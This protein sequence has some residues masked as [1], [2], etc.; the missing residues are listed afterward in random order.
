M[1][2][3]GHGSKGENKQKWKLNSSA[4]KVDRKL[5]ERKA[6]KR[7]EMAAEQEKGSGNLE[8]NWSAERNYKWQGDQK[9]SKTRDI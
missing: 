8:G 2:I 9:T 5:R 6:E 3:L 4:Y 7:G 1:G